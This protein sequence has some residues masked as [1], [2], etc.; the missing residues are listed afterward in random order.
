MGL[1]L[2]WQLDRRPD[3]IPVETEVPCERTDC[4]ADKI[5]KVQVRVIY[6]IDSLRTNDFWAFKCVRHFSIGLP[7]HRSSAEF[8]VI[9]YSKAPFTLS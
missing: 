7:L 6:V 4:V 3:P 8:T 1:R 5:E 2:L 9:A